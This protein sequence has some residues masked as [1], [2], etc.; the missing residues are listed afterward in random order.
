M[1]AQPDSQPRQNPR[2]RLSPVPVFRRGAA[3]LRLV[4]R[5]FSRREIIVRLLGLSPVHPPSD[6]PGLIILQIDGLS[7]PRLDQAIKRRRMPF[8]ASLVKRDRYHIETMYSGQPATTPAVLGELFYGVEQAVPAYSFR[9]HRTGKV[10]EMLDPEIAEPIQKELAAKGA[11][12]LTGG[13]AY[14]DIYAGGAEEAQFCPG[15]SRWRRLDEAS[16]WAK[17]IILLLHLPALARTA[18]AIVRELFLSDVALDPQAIAGSQL[19]LR[20]QIHPPPPR[21]QRRPQ[22][23]DRGRD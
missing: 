22:G 18:G 2:T 1:S 23:S 21:G 11:G 19:D 7:R 12:L 14:C 8:I 16:V 5:W 9:D 4:R 10:F 6:D 20:D 17:A 15:R 13:A 3:A